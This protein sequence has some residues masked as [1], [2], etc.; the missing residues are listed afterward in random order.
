MLA[1]AI[2]YVAGYER[3]YS[4]LVAEENYLQITRSERRQVGSDLLL[5]RR[6]GADGW[7]SFRD[8]FE[9]N[10]TPVR[11]REDRL[12]RLFLDPSAETEV[13]LKAIMEDSARYNI[14]QL[15]RNINVPLYP[16]KFLYAENVSRFAF[17]FDGTGNVGGVEAT[18]IAFEERARPTVVRLNR[19]SDV[20]AA[21]SFLVDPASGAI[22]G[23]RT[24]LEWDHGRSLAEFVVHYARN[25]TLGLWVPAQMTEGFWAGNVGA[26]DRV[27]VLEARA[28]Y[29]KFRRFQVKTEEQM[30]I[31]K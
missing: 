30:T 28:T 2:D 25:A 22:V 15:E 18:R 19:E 6:P 26:I 29:S 14:G 20:P 13:Q 11:D 23:T 8:V 12:K 9:V 3:E 16:L 5:V 31:Q 4:L 10:G 27:R 1:R 24:E 7:V 17:R 21:G